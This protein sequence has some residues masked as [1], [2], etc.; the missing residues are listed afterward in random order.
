MPLLAD[1]CYAAAADDAGAL[2]S[3][4][5]ACAAALAPK[6]T[7]ALNTNCMLPGPPCGLCTLHILLPISDAL[8]VLLQQQLLPIAAAVTATAASSPDD[9]FALHYGIFA[10]EL[11]AALLI[12]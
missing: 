6:G 11:A 12:S 4:P 10:V 2:Q 3:D 1:D 7:Q 5:A 9:P 8:S